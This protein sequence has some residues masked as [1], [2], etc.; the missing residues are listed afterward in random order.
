MS[1]RDGL[2]GYYGIAGLRGVV[3]IS[4]YHLF[5]FPKEVEARP[6]GFR[7]PVR[8]RLRTSDSE[9]YK[10]VLRGEYSFELP[11]SPKIIVDAGANIG[12]AS[13]YFAH[14]YP[15]AKII[16]IEA[17][18]S[19]FDI[20]RRN[21]R[22]YPAI[23]PVHAA[24]WNRD[25]EISV[26]EPDARTGASGKWGFVTRENGAGAKVRAVTMGTLM[27]EMNIRA[28]DLAK[29]DIEGAEQEVFED[30]RWL[31]G[32]QCLM[33]ELHDLIRPGCAA[34]VNF[35]LREFERTERGATSFYLRRT[36]TAQQQSPERTRSV[37]NERPSGRGVLAP[38]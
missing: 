9:T 11:F 2:K 5:G 24:V 36:S 23:T 22:Y 10:E 38:C 18:A 19:N 34:V 6:A 27:R 13:L 37:D 33:I 30:T 31:T 21:V 29:I 3:A 8:I 14:K 17:E 32:V 1:I 7:T 16:A 26:S 4:G 25:G 28:I 20:L 15:D 35:A 12:M